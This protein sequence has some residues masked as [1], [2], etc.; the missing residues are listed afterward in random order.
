MSIVRSNYKLVICNY[1]HQKYKA[2]VIWQKS[3]SK[4]L[5]SIRAIGVAKFLKIQDAKVFKLEFEH[6]LNAF[7]M[8]ASFKD[9]WA[10]FHGKC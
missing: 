9:L 10:G 3:I 1:A 5:V 6:N 7:G 8:H 2:I 4:G